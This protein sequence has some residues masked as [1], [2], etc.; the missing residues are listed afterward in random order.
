[1]DNDTIRLYQYPLVE[2]GFYK[3]FKTFIKNRR[4]I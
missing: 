4:R 1:M 2:Y 3:N